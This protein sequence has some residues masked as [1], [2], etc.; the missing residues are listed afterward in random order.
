MPTRA[1]PSL[2]F[3]EMHRGARA[4]AP[5]ELLFAGTGLGCGQM[6]QSIDGQTVADLLDEH[7]GQVPGF[8]AMRFLA[9]SVVLVAHSFGVAENRQSDEP[10]LYYT[11]VIELGHLGVFVFFFISGFV[12]TQ[13]CMRSSPL[14]FLIKRTARIM[15]GL[16]LVTIFCALLLGPLMTSYSLRDYFT[17]R[18]RRMRFASG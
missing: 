11:K 5:P 14:S 17:D 18:K 2:M 7:K 13:S 8:N 1:S 15:P 4:N 10:L 3:Q 9:A 16:I 12:I 6:L